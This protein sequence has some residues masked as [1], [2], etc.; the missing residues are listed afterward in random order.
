[1]ISVSPDFITAIQNGVIKPEP[2]CLISW[3]KNINPGV[4][5]FQL[6]HSYLDG[7]DKLKGSGD[8]VTFFDAFDYIDETAYVKNFRITKKTSSRPWGVIMATA[9]VEL[10]NTTRRFMPGFDPVIGACTDLPDR[11]IKLSVGFNGEFIKLFTG[12]AERPNHGL[13]KRTTT[14]TAYDA[15]TYLSTVKSNLGAYVDTPMHEIIEDLLIEQGFGLDQFNIEPSLQQPIG[16]YM[17]NGKIVTDIFQEFCEAE[18]YLLQADEDGIIQGWNRLHFLGDRTSVW[19]FNYSNMADVKWSSAPIINSVQFEAKPLKPAAWNKLYETDNSPEDRM[20]PP[21]GSKDIFA[22][23]KDDLGSF[24]AITVETPV[25]ISV[26]DAGSSYSTNMSKDGDAETGAAFITL[27]SVY[28]FGS[29]YRMTFSNSSNAPVYITKIQ[30]FGQP[31]KVTAI[32]GE[33][34]ENQTSIDKYGLNPDNKKEVY[35][36]N[37][38]VVQDVVTANA[39]AWL[40]VD[41]N[42]NPHARM[43]V[44][45]FV[46]PHLQIGDPVEAYIE[47]IDDTKY[48]NV[49]GV[50]I[51]LG[52]NVNM[53]QT[54][55]IEEREQKTYFRLDHSHLDGSDVLAL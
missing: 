52:V 36:I 51:F 11:P 33:I 20:V 35:V 46:A 40:T 16:Y 23:F 28:N 49:M 6:D 45:N 25:H 8:T 44:D 34:Q 24:P 38:D 2:G 9:E 42:S 12:Y 32:K 43:D 37:S 22:E 10:N 55:Y 5:F 21:G 41:I 7:P 50:E 18:G 14:I 31:A 3:P 54:T 30:L 39:M 47:D 48:C 1:M 19:T 53:T 27:G 29:S 15:M 4:K 13:V 17:P 26:A